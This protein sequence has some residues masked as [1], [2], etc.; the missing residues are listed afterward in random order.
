ML[1]NRMI[2]RNRM[3]ALRGRPSD[4]FEGIGAHRT[5]LRLRVEGVIALGLAIGA[6]GLT[7]AEWL[8]TLAPLAHRFG[9]S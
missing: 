3:I 8:R 5:Y 1:E 6:C 7:A 9:L 4:P 2:G